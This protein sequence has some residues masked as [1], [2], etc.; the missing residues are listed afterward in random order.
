MANKE[1]DSIIYTW[2]YKLIVG[3][4]S[5]LF[6]KKFTKIHLST[7]SSVWIDVWNVM[8]LAW[9]LFVFLM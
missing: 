5:I 3:V 4:Y 9:V 6:V 1:N 7:F 8:E 2:E